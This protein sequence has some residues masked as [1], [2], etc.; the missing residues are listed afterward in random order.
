MQK[1]TF[2]SGCAWSIDCVTV[3][4]LGREHALVLGDD[5]R[6]RRDLL[7][8]VDRAVDA[9]AAG[10][11]DLVRQQRDLRLAAEVRVDPPARVSAD[12]R[13]ALRGC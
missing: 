5:L 11:L 1:M 3:Q 12:E 7:E 9:V 4:A 2:R 6:A 8:R 10:L 13:G